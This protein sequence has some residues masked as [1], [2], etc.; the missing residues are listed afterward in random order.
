MLFVQ[1]SL[2]R[3]FRHRQYIEYHTH[4]REYHLLLSYCF[5]LVYEEGYRGQIL[6]SCYGRW[7]R[8]GQFRIIHLNNVAHPSIDFQ[9]DE[10]SS[11]YKLIQNVFVCIIDISPQCC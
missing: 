8:K 5:P 11:F 2:P 9:L 6:E 1:Q 10:H 7:I 4:I 3:I